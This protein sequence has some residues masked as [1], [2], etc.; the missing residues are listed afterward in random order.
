MVKIGVLMGGK[1]AE[2]DISL[3]T[4]TAF[5]EA[6]KRKGYD[7][8]GIDV[9]EDIALV[10][11]QQKIDVAFIALHGRFGED[12]TIQGL[13]E[14]MGIPYTGSGVLASSLAMNKIMAKKIF[15]HQGISTP[16]FI[17]AEIDEAF[18][19]SLL[20][21]DE[22]NF[23]LVIK[24]DIEGSSFGLSIVNNIDE[25]SDALSKAACYSKEI[26]IEEYVAGMEITIGILGKDDVK[27]LPIIQIKPK[28]GIYDYE[29]KYT[30]GATE[31]V[32]P[33]PLE[34][35]TYKKAQSMAL[36]AHK[37]LGCEGVS[38]VDMMVDENGTPYVL[39]VNTIPGMTGTSLLPQA[40]RYIGLEF[41]DLVEK[42][43]LMV[44]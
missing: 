18:D 32:I 25:I 11:R 40:A 1:S 24:P 34:E 4:G 9:N 10:L 26:L 15:E 43:L 28:K 36:S 13:L 31:F 23:P 8:V 16:R 42:I 7:V 30:K 35:A 33:A 29:A 5:V 14:I 6:I 2:R 44:F 27:P 39:E 21:L 38:R 19:V 37:A 22:M 3:K 12:G 41:D 20:K 17:A